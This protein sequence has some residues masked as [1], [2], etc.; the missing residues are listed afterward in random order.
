MED[1]IHKYCMSTNVITKSIILERYKEFLFLHVLSGSGYSSSFYHVGKV[2]FW[3]SWLVNQDEPVAF[4][5]LRDCPSLPLKKEYINVIER[6]ISF[7]YYDDCN[8]F[9]IIWLSMKSESINKTWT[10]HLY[11]RQKML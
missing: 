5:R 1:T 4:I 6:F 3:K 8:C 7:L 9:S 10:L 2:K 11:L